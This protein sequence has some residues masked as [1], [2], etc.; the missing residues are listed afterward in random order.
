MTELSNSPQATPAIADNE[1][2]ESATQIRVLHVDDD[3]SFTELVAT[4]LERES[5]RLTVTTASNATEGLAALNEKRLD[6]IVSDFDMPGRNG[7]EFLEAVR[8]TH[9]NLPFI[10]FTGKG[11]EEV[12]S[13]AISAGATDYLQKGG[14]SDQYE[15]LANRIENSVQHRFAEN[16]LKRERTR[17]EFALDA[18]SAC[19]WT[20]NIETDTMAIH[21][22]PD[23]VFGMSVDCFDDIIEKA[24]PEDCDRLSEAIESTADV[25]DSCAVQFRF[26]GPART[27][28]AEITART[29]DRDELPS[30]QT[31]ITRDITTRKEQENRFERLVNNL[32]GMVY[33]CQYT[34]SWQ[35]NDVRGEVE[36]FTGYTAA[37]LESNA[38]QWGE[39]VI[40]EADQEFVWETI[41]E[42]VETNDSFDLTYRIRTK[43][44]DIRWVWERGR[45]VYDSNGDIRNLEGFIADVTDSRIQEQR[46]RALFEDP[47]LLV[48]SLELDGTIID[49]NDTAMTY[50]D[51]DRSEVVGTHFWENSWWA[52]DIAGD[53]KEWVERAASGEYVRYSA[54]HYRS[55]GTP[56]SVE[57]TLRPVTS[58][59]GEVTSLIVSSRKVQPSESN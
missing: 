35:M 27:R 7:I 44:G 39:E 18:T 55:D 57:G 15:L 24:H 52:D 26:I 25:G 12:A 22:N 43:G 3:P 45:A 17:I 13:D 1:S 53:V 2:A 46:Y 34:H 38:I 6:C 29:I 4:F 31:G 41:R 8:E 48:G 49:V 21:P 5:F 54:E 19:V 40:H 37:E 16:Q 47:N 58:D 51:V 33:R 11:S 20:R 59:T 56:V 23:P 28:W 9:P 10:L 36:S 42:D 30:Y 32:P 50:V 14:G